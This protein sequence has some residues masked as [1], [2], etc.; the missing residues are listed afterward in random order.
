MQSP[1]CT[2]RLGRAF[3]GTALTGA[4]RFVLAKQIKVLYTSRETA[5]TVQR[6]FCTSK[7]DILG[8]SSNILVPNICILKIHILGPNSCK[9]LKFGTQYTY[10]FKIKLYVNWVPKLMKLL[11]FTYIGPNGSKRCQ[12]AAVTLGPWQGGLGGVKVISNA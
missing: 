6:A 7:I 11:L 5:L 8:P 1:L 2:C 4:S 12:G 3:T 9:T 10:S